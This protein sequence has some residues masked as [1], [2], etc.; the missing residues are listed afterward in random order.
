MLNKVKYG[1]REKIISSTKEGTADISDAINSLQASVD[2][3]TRSMDEYKKVSR[4]ITELRKEVDRIASDYAFVSPEYLPAAPSPSKKRLLICGFYGAKNLGDELMLQALLSR[5]DKKKYDITIM[6]ARHKENDMSCY[7][8]FRV[9]H[10]PKK[11]DDILNIVHNYDLLVWG[12][13]AILDDSEYGFNGS[14]TPLGYIFTKSCMAMICAEKPVYILGVSTNQHFENETFIDDLNFIVKRA[15]YFSLRDTNSKETLEAARIDTSKIKIIDDLT[16]PDI[17]VKIEVKKPS[18]N[19]LHIG[20]VLINSWDY[21][22]KFS[23]FLKNL[24]SSEQDKK[25]VF[26]FIPFYDY[27]DLDINGYKT[28]AE[29]AGVEYVIEKNPRNMDE[30]ANELLSCEIVFS[31]RYHGVLIASLLGI[32]TVSID[33]SKDHPHY[34]NKLKYIKEKYN[35][36][37]VSIDASDLAKLD[38]VKNALGEIERSHQ[39]L[40]NKKIVDSASKNLDTLLS[41][42]F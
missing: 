13:G 35:N 1:L 5:V 2:D 10:Y 7:S 27:V 12:G 26:H 28:V 19:S 38:K 41:T 36:S 23:L 39:I 24:V 3:L 31:M 9:I 25:I 16:I 29:S 4:T 15:N 11:N 8:P 6:T 18:D 14:K 22:E 17:P 34:Y 20:I 33:L 32:R 21:V 30:L 37:L 42:L 40:G